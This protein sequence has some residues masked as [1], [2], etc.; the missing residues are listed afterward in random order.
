MRAHS[1][2]TGLIPKLTGKSNFNKWAEGVRICSGSL[3]PEHPLGGL[4][5]LRFRNREE[6]GESD[7]FHQQGFEYFEIP[8]MPE[9]LSGNASGAT[10]QKHKDEKEMFQKFSAAKNQ[11][12]NEITVSL[13]EV[14]EGFQT[15]SGQLLRMNPYQFLTLATE[16]FGTLNQE[17]IERLKDSLRIKF[18]GP[19]QSEP[20]RK[21]TLLRNQAVE[22]LA[23]AGQPLSESDLISSLQVSCETHPHITKAISDYLLRP[24]QRVMANRKCKNVVTEVI[25]Y[26]G[27]V[28]IAPST[29]GIAMSATT[30]TSSAEAK[31]IAELQK[32]VNAMSKQLARLSKP[33]ATFSAGGGEHESSASYYCYQH[34]RSGNGDISGY[35]ADQCPKIQGTIARAS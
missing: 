31:L 11:L 29:M 13:Q 4:T 33:G 2:S 32:Q 20:F 17:D 23:K 16:L 19:E 5:Q 6:Y 7:E 14:I 28:S 3:F 35:S 24:E 15:D 8:E 34:G 18:T 22:E 1:E 21:F 25:S 10:I 30:T 26:L 9:A 27:S 12:V